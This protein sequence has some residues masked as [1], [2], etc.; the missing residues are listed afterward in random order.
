M[1]LLVSTIGFLA[2]VL[3]H[4]D[5]AVESIMADIPVAGVL[6]VVGVLEVAD[7]PA[8]PDVPLLLTSVPLLTYLLF[9]A[10]RP[11]IP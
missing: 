7:V 10:S 11:S 3:L 2:T 9:L 5:R 4:S 8:A 6:N 1:L